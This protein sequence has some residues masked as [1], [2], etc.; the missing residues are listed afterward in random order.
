MVLLVTNT[1]RKD[2]IMTLEEIRKKYNV[3]KFIED[4]EKK[5]TH[6]G[7]SCAAAWQAIMN[8]PND[9]WIRIVAKDQFRLW[10]ERRM[11]EIINAVS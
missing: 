9:E 8:S 3:D 4:V 2:V 10:T 7:V 1:S 6:D 5:A 11:T